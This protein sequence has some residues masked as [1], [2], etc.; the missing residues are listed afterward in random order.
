MG[1][2]ETKPR[3]MLRV[4]MRE[5]RQSGESR[6]KDIGESKTSHTK[7]SGRTALSLLN[8]HLTELENN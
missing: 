2:V 7:P 5:G 8:P 6:P 3:A 1:D 4:S